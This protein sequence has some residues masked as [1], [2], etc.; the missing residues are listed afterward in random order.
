MKKI[1]ISEEYSDN[2][3]T[4]IDGVIFRDVI[5]FPYLVKAINNKGKIIIDFDDCY[6][7]GLPFLREVFGGLIRV[8]NYK[9]KT[10]LNT[11]EFISRD[12]ETLI[13][14]VHRYLNQAEN[15]IKNNKR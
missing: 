14:S 1:K 11:V 7:V 15:D 6:G 10:I 2:P 8:Y 3:C 5:L 12:D 9:K 13:E 4:T